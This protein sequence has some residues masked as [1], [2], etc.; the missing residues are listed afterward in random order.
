MDFKTSTSTAETDCHFKLWFFFSLLSFLIIYSR[1]MFVRTVHCCWLCK[2]LSGHFKILSCL[3]CIKAYTAAILNIKGIYMSC[4]L[5]Y[6]GLPPAILNIKG[7][8]MS[9]ALLHQG[10]PPAILKSKKYTCPAALLYQ[11]LPP[12]IKYPACTVSTW[13]ELI[14][15]SGLLWYQSLPPAISNIE[16]NV[17]ALGL[18]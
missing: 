3:H 13:K 4:P 18:L 12:G 16:G 17:Q 1:K 10:L 2:Y 6:Q 7:I 14:Y 8:Y 11:G 15:K 9:C 5:L